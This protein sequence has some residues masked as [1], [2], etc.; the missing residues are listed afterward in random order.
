MPE[1]ERDDLLAK[2]REFLDTYFRKGAEFAQELLHDNEGLRFRVIQ[3]EEEVAAAR[4]SA[5]PSAAVRELLE[6]IEL[7]EREKLALLSR[8]QQVEALHRDFEARYEEIERENNDLANL[9]IASSQ[10]NAAL[11]PADILATAV[12]IVLNFV[13]GKVFAVLWAD[14]D[15]RL[16]ALA[17]EGLD[18]DEA[19]PLAPDRG[20]AGEALRTGTAAYA[21]RELRPHTFDPERPLVCVPLRLGAETVGALVI[22]AFLPQKEA[23]ANVDHELFKLLGA[24]V[25]P[26]LKAARLAASPDGAAGRLTLHGLR[27]SLAGHADKG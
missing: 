21:E 24:Q 4:R 9:Y 18:P 26:A 11:A 20:L 19:P 23:F 16:G 3:L 6:R 25:A 14:D 7:L 13:G 22:W 17:A 8:H 10:L 5:P 27:E 12:E 15:G 1:K 2:R